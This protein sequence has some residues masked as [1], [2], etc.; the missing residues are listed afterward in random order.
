M[1]FIV[2]T[3]SA[4][5][6]FEMFNL[7]KQVGNKAFKTLLGYAFIPEIICS[8]IL[9]IIAMTTG[10]LTAVLISILAGTFFTATLNV[11]KKVVGTRKYVKNETTGKREWVET[12]GMPFAEYV[13]TFSTNI[14]SK[15]ISF[16]NA[17]L[18]KRASA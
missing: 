7:F 15:T 3:A 5:T 13:R 2:I 10:S 16:T 14:V 1:L 6:C 17:V 4:L 9:P 12:D 18:G 8:L 11:C